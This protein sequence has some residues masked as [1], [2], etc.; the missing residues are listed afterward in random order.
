M[1]G[2]LLLT[3][4]AFA[5]QQT[6]VIPALP[7][8]E[9]S[10]HASTTLTAWLLSGYLIIASVAT[11][12]VGKLGD[13]RGKRLMIL[14]ALVVFF[15]GSVGA[16]LSP[17]IWVLI[18]FRGLQGVGGAV[19]PLSFSVARDELS[20][21]HIGTAIGELTGSF[22]V[23]T[24]IGLGLGG[25]IAGSLSWR[26]IFAI[27]GLT[28][29]GAI[30]LVVVLVPESRRGAREKLDIT[31]GLI[32]GG[33][34]AALLLAVTEGVRLG[35]T[36]IP[37]IGRFVAAAGLMVLWVY[38]E[39]RT[40]SPL[41]DLKVLAAP[42]V[43]LTNLATI[44]LG[45]LLFGTYFLIP[46]FV[47]V[48]SRYGFAVGAAGAGLYL[49]PGAIGQLLTG[50]FSGVVERKSSPKWLLAAAL[51]LAGSGAAA[52]ALWN[53]HPWEVVAWVFVLGCGIGLGISAGGAL[54]TGAVSE[55]D[56]GISNSFNS[57]LRRVGG[58][59][60]S[61][62]GAALLAAFTVTGSLPVERAF[63]VAFAIS[64]GLCL[65]GAGCAVFIPGTEVG[66]A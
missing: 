32:F 31:G 12:L 57:V 19:F 1:L 5:F 4:V 21:D 11:P 25:I 22:G 18:A 9:R 8:I 61:Q 59:I 63:V 51:G 26:L 41:L 43:L 54:V 27:G 64:A 58:G 3:N 46:H 16:A 42:A 28:I 49:L 48:P 17:N 30:I 47:E 10:L 62:V 33:A 55:Q 65:L 53:G 39:S 2:A 36:S 23:G 29:A 34:L 15:V 13:Q 24:A 7:T 37:I 45:Y 44:A 14:A 35:W 56:T 60:G 38:H 20:G 66:R 6:A 40:E 52:L 50:T